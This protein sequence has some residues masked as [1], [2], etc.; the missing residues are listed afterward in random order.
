M[1]KPGLFFYFLLTLLVHQPSSM[2]SVFPSGFKVSLLDVESVVRQSN[3]IPRS[4]IIRWRNGPI[5][6]GQ[7]E[8]EGGTSGDYNNNNYCCC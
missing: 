2:D 8:D 1:Q 7:E 3:S 4:K 5:R 6:P